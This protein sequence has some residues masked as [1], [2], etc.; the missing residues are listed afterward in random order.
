[1]RHRILLVAIFVLFIGFLL[2]FQRA[3]A[4]SIL[5]QNSEHDAASNDF[6]QHLETKKEDIQADAMRQYR[7]MKQEGK[8]VKK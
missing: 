7:Q 5:E 1:M 8:T 6:W 2:L 4:P 3:F